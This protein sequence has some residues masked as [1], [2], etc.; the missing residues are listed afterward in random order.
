MSIRRWLVCP[1]TQRALYLGS[2]CEWLTPERY[3]DQAPDS[4]SPIFKAIRSNRPDGDCVEWVYRWHYLWAGRGGGWVGGARI[5]NDSDDSH[6]VMIFGDPRDWPGGIRAGWVVDDLADG[7]LRDGK[8][9]IP[10]SWCFATWQW[11]ALPEDAKARALATHV[12]W[13][14]GVLMDFGW[15]GFPS[16]R[17]GWV[18]GDDSDDG[19]AFFI[20]S[21]DRRAHLTPEGVALLAGVVPGLLPPA[22]DSP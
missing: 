15:R 5:V 9:L 6:E 13:P 3:A 16:T 7:I 19:R 14:P 18:R 11:L 22:E 12:E 4:L 8:H 20:D 2:A 21:E 17:G 1:S 10:L